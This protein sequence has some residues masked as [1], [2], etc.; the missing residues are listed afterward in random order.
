MRGPTR[1]RMAVVL[2]V[3]LVSLTG[4]L[5][6]VPPHAVTAAPMQDAQ[7]ARTATPQG[8]VAAQPVSSP[9]PT[10][11][12]PGS[13]DPAVQDLDRQ[14]QALQTQ[15]HT[16]LDPLEK[17]VKAL[18]DQFD[19]QIK[20]LV[21]RR[22]DLVEAGKPAD[23]QELDRQ[24]AAELSSLVDQEKAEIEKVRQH[25]TEERSDVQAKYKKLREDAK[26]HKP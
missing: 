20:S 13:P 3:V 7:A 19:P 12:H 6:G 10:G 24:E 25:Y 4:G 22:H 9:V 17:Q 14:I 16:Q 26:G 5:G 1:M 11:S 8:G 15:F 2:A 23:I 18:R 21:E